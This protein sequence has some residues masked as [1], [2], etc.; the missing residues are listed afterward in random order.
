MEI[1]VRHLRERALTEGPVVSI[2]SDDVVE[3]HSVTIHGACLLVTSATLPG[4][5]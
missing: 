3:I 4:A 5:G 2:R 1:G